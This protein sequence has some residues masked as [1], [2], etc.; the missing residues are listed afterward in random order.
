MHYCMDK[1]D[2]WGLVSEGSAICSVCGMEKIDKEDGCCKDESKFLKNTS[3]QQ[4]SE[5]AIQLIQVTGAALP[6]SL[7]DRHLVYAG[8]HEYENFHLNPLN[9]SSH[10][11]VYI[12]NCIFR[13]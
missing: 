4:N 13:I 1:M 9:R 2:G 10:P 3:D 8:V 11:P 7:L 5:I 12:L 6:A